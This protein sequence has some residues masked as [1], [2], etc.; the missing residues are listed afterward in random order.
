MKIIAL[1]ENKS[2]GNLKAEHGLSVYIEY[3]GKKYLLDAGTTEAYMENAKKLGIDL[4]QVDMGVLSHNHFDHAGGFGR[5]FEMNPQASV[6]VRDK[7]S[8]PC[9]DKFGFITHYIGIP[10][11]ILKNYGHRFKYISGNYQLADGVWLLPHTTSGLQ[12]RGKAAHL[13]RKVDG[14]IV[15]DDFAHEQSLVFECAEGLVIFNSC[16]HGGVDNVIKEVQAVFPE[17]KILAMIGGFHLMGLLG[18]KTMSGKPEDVKALANRVK[19]L[20]VKEIHTCHCTGTP[21]FNILKEEL[22]EQIHYFSTGTIL[23]YKE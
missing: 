19:V 13:A 23:E 21:A 11:R 18:A 6:Y 3:G 10:K 1:I 5:F 12:A 17:K 8:E 14:K 16:S 22:G 4:G 2:N 15:Y 20:D 7:G 9:Y